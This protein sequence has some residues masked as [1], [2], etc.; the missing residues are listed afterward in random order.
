[1]NLQSRYAP[2]IALAILGIVVV[3]VLGWFLAVKPQFDKADDARSQ[4]T[5]INANT[6]L[7]KAASTQLDAYAELL[8]S[9][10]GTDAALALNAPSTF[11]L[12]GFRTRLDAAVRDSGV[13]LLGAIQVEAAS[14]EGWPSDGVVLTSNSVAALFSQGPV[15]SGA[16]DSSAA[17]VPTAT[18]SPTDGAT[19][20]VTSGW[21]PAIVPVAEAGPIAGSMSRVEFQL[22]LVGTASEIHAFLQRMADPSAQL[23]QISQVT[24]TAGGDASNAIGSPTPNEN[25]LAVAVVASLYFHEPDASIVDEEGIQTANPKDDAFATN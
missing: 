25:D 24:Q 2:V 13:D 5:E 10:T 4:T 19:P 6:E 20:P 11:D 9:D 21:A 17:P 23:F 12:Q 22:E 3:G 7:L 18:A 15:G 14:V 16:P 1:M 8:A